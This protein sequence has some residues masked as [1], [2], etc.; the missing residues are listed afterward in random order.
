M[1]RRAGRRDCGIAI[2]L[3]RHKRMRLAVRHKIRDTLYAIIVNIILFGVL[4]PVVSFCSR[5]GRILVCD[6]TLAQIWLRSSSLSTK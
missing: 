6:D 4:A 5:R 1:L 3:A 2:A